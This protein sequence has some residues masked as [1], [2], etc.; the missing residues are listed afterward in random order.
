MSYPK[1]LPNLLFSSKVRATIS[2]TYTDLIIGLLTDMDD[3]ELAEAVRIVCVTSEILIV[4]I[5]CIARKTC[6]TQKVSP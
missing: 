1:H 2:L 4:L 5:E 6:R 3:S